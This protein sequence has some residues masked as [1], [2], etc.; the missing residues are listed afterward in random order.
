MK[1]FQNK[2]IVFVQIIPPA[3][4]IARRSGYSNVDAIIPSPVVQ[5]INGSCGTYL[6]ESSSLTA[7]HVSEFEKLSK[8]ER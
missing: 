2:N 5:K 3:E 4:W 8:T 1:T 7:M 6:Y